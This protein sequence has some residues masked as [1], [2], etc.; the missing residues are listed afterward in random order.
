M[1]EDGTIT[2][3]DGTAIDPA[4]VPRRPD[5]RDKGGMGGGFRPGMDAQAGES[6]PSGVFAIRN[7]GNMFCGVGAPE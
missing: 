4:G 5:G 1:N 3:P 2:L 6:E 7:G